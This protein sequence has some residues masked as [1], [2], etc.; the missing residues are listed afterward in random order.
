MTRESNN[1]KED[2]LYQCPVI[3][4][5][6]ETGRGDYFYKENSA[7]PI[8]EVHDYA[9][10]QVTSSNMIKI[11][12]GGAFVDDPGSLIKDFDNNT[13]TEFVHDTNKCLR[14]P[15]SVCHSDLDCVSN[16]KITGLTKIIDT[17]ND[18]DL[19]GNTELNRYEAEFWQSELICSQYHDKT[20][21]KYELKN[22][23]C[24][25]DSGLE[26]SLPTKTLNNL[27]ESSTS[28]LQRPKIFDSE[29]QIV[30]SST[31]SENNF[32][33]YKRLTQLALLAKEESLSS[34][35]I[36]VAKSPEDYDCNDGACSAP[37]ENE[38][39]KVQIM[40]KKMCCSGHF[41]RNWHERNGGGHGYTN[42]KVNDFNLKNFQCLNWFPTT[43]N[44]AVPPTPVG[45]WKP[46]SCAGL[47]AIGDCTTVIRNIPSEE[48]KRIQNFLALFDLLGIPQ[49]SIEHGTNVI[50]C[51]SNPDD[52]TALGATT[53][54]LPNLFENAPTAGIMGYEYGS[55][56]Y[57]ADHPTEDDDAS[58]FDFGGS[59]DEEKMK[60]VWSRDKFT[61]CLPTN[62]VID[63]G[64]PHSRCCSNYAENIATVVDGVAQNQMTCKLP[65]EIDITLFA[66]KFV[67]TLGDELG[68]DESDYDPQ[69][70]FPTVSVEDIFVKACELD[71]CGSGVVVAGVAYGEFLPYGLESSDITF[72]RYRFLQDDEDGNFP[73]LFTE[74]KLKWRNHVYC[75]P[76]DGASANLS[77]MAAAVLSF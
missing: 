69:T 73:G 7:N 32:E 8:E 49:I 50:D 9:V 55:S 74:N 57:S 47:T 4:T 46:F 27:S 58:G 14:L 1:S 26:Y 5:I 71:L 67:S 21:K 44:G 19:D 68:F 24:C 10:A 25:R 61:C 60:K 72:R 59:E 16:E 70:G 40:G 22:N 33:S 37:Y 53:P 45:D 12:E 43:S 42:D 30:P 48:A 62:S 2:Y 35:S 20:D 36:K 13:I 6:D 15:G 77:N 34:D 52:Q 76:R 39:K 65:D 18:E 29:T 23:R 11:F 3:E 75:L 28:T 63:Q 38:Y 17:E 64:D 31:L 54:T 56:A 51:I 66:N 41:V